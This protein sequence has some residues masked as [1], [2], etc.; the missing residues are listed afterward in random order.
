MRSFPLRP[1]LG[2]LLGCP[3]KR[4]SPWVSARR[5]T[6]RQAGGLLRIARN[7]L[8]GALPAVIPGHSCT[9]NTTPNSREQLFGENRYLASRKK[10]CSVSYLHCT[11]RELY[12]LLICFLF[13]ISATS[14]QLAP[15]FSVVSCTI[16]LHSASPELSTT[17]TSFDYRGPAS[18]PNVR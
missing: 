6:E 7:P 5:D 3:L 14:P 12:I 15:S 11:K 16:F 10:S 18:D 9:I 13:S 4:G 1:S 17:A 2:R 8:V